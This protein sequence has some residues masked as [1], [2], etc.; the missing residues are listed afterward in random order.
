MTFRLDYYDPAELGD[1]RA[2]LGAHPRRRDRGRGGRR[3]RAP[4]A[5]NAAHRKPDPAARPRRRAGEA[6]RRDHDG[7]RARGARAARGRRR[8]AR[9]DRPRAAR[10]RSCGSSAAARSAC[11]R[12]RS[13]SARSRTRS[14][15]STSRTCSSSASS[16]A[17]RAGASSP[18]SAASTSARRRADDAALLS[19]GALGPGRGRAVP[20]RLRR[21]CPPADRAL[22]VEHAAE[23][24]HVEVELGDGERFARS[25]SGEPGYGFLTL[26]RPRSPT[27]ATEELIVPVGAI[28]R[29]ALGPADEATPPGLRASRQDEGPEPAA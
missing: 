6:R 7:G 13:R 2:P 23:Q 28:R 27:A 10:A 24:T 12:S 3:D 9:A 1:D 16:S 15:T 11:R 20:R 29:I 19:P 17:R 26:V 25:L 4:L 5:R 22:H 21:A 8:R 14:R 18:S